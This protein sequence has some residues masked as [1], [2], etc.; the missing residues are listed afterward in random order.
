MN[1]QLGISALLQKHTGVGGS[2]W[3]VGLNQVLILNEG[4]GGEAIRVDIGIDRRRA[5]TDPDVVDTAS[6]HPEA[7]DMP[8]F[9]PDTARLLTVEQQCERLEESLQMLR[10]LVHGEGGNGSQLVYSEDLAILVGEVD[11]MCDLVCLTVGYWSLT[12]SP[13]RGNRIEQKTQALASAGEEPKRWWF[14]AMTQIHANAMHRRVPTVP[15]AHWMYGPD[16]NLGGGTWRDNLGKKRE[17]GGTQRVIGL[18]DIVPGAFWADL[19]TYS[20]GECNSE[21]TAVRQALYQAMLGVQKS[22]LS[23][24]TEL[25]CVQ[26]GDVQTW[27][28]SGEAC[29]QQYGLPVTSETS[30]GSQIVLAGDPKLAAT[31]DRQFQVKDVHIAVERHIAAV[32][33]L[34]ALI[35]KEGDVGRALE[36]LAVATDT[37]TPNLRRAQGPYLPFQRCYG[38]NVH[39]E[40]YPAIASWGDNAWSN[41]GFS[42]SGVWGRREVEEGSLS[43]QHPDDG[44]SEYKRYGRLQS[45]QMQ[46]TTRFL[47]LPH[48]LRNFP[49][50]CGLLET[51]PLPSMFGNGVRLY[52]TEEC[53]RRD[54]LSVSSVVERE[55][56][57]ALEEYALVSKTAWIDHFEP[58]SLASDLTPIEPMSQLARQEL[59][60][61]KSLLAGTSDTGDRETVEFA[62]LSRIGTDTTPYIAATTE[63][64]LFCK[65]MRDIVASQVKQMQSVARTGAKQ[66]SEDALAD[67]DC[68]SYFGVLRHLNSLAEVQ[69][70]PE[71]S[72]QLTSAIDWCRG[73]VKTALDKRS[74]TR[75]KLKPKPLSAS[76]KRNATA[77]SSA[78]VV[79]SPS[80]SM[81]SKFHQAFKLACETLDL[82]AARNHDPQSQIIR[83]CKEWILA[84][85]THARLSRSASVMTVHCQ[86]GMVYEP[87]IRHFLCTS[88]GRL[89]R[90]LVGIDMGGGC[91]LRD[92]PLTEMFAGCTYFASGSTRRGDPWPRLSALQFG[93]EAIMGEIRRS[94]MLLRQGGA[95]ETAN[96]ELKPGVLRQSDAEV[97]RERWRR[98][99]AH[100]F[101]PSQ[102]FGD[103]LCVLNLHYMYDNCAASRNSLLKIIS[104]LDDAEL[105]LCKQW[106]TY[107]HGPHPFAPISQSECEY[108]NGWGDLNQAVPERE[109]AKATACTVRGEHIQTRQ[110][111]RSPRPI[112]ST[113][114][115]TRLLESERLCRIYH[116]LLSVFRAGQLSPNRLVKDITYLVSVHTPLPQQWMTVFIDLK[117]DA[118][119]FLSDRKSREQ[120]SEEALS[121]FRDHDAWIS[122]S[123]GADAPRILDQTGRVQWDLLRAL[124]DQPRQNHQARYGKLLQLASSL[125]F[126]KLLRTPFRAFDRNTFPNYGVVQKFQTADET[127]TDH[128]CNS[129]SADATRVEYWP[130]PKVDEP[131]ATSP[132]GMSRADVY[133]LVHRDNVDGRG[134][135]PSEGWGRRF[136]LDS[137]DFG[138]LEG[139]EV[140]VYSTSQGCIGETADLPEPEDNPQF[141]ILVQEL[142]QKVKYRPEELVRTGQRWIRNGLNCV[143]GHDDDG[144]HPMEE[145]S[146]G[147]GRER[148]VTQSASIPPNPDLLE[149]LSLEEQQELIRERRLQSGAEGM[150]ERS[151]SAH[152]PPA[153][154]N[155]L[156]QDLR[157][158]VRTDTA[159]KKALKWIPNDTD[160][161]VSTKTTGSWEFLPAGYEQVDQRGTVRERTSESP[162]TS[163]G[164][165]P[166]PRGVVLH[167]KHLHV[168]GDKNESDS[169]S[170]SSVSDS[171]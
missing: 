156:P 119:L 68:K 6:L 167:P 35:G 104:L 23:L 31:V 13:G 105:N 53:L 4:A 120:L 99:S 3:A 16:N 110:T 22:G 38:N 112:V 73:E 58:L 116:S 158:V 129:L 43:M 98:S 95:L 157:D 144:D 168:R 137:L 140:L 33:G 111:G 169:I 59:Q 15:A 7:E 124:L 69:R 159:V 165:H 152:L 1:L 85:Q 143:G 27:T 122:T 5:R 117:E 141:Q 65:G 42:T 28:S 114:L 108:P 171:D 21:K 19:D 20:R 34:L 51:H 107:S 54:L 121:A 139:E 145:I 138:S 72:A 97:K 132:R 91:L 146:H 151:P 2:H 66:F 77:P 92:E 136:G 170:D 149:P 49:F 103:E 79:Y 123:A 166:V 10:L 74:K 100:A 153:K 76:A 161:R 24:R 150:R 39:L 93:A 57:L 8:G 78:L 11:R 163:V 148:G 36:A 102:F 142:L 113:L 147:W 106:V 75:S 128:R 109:L 50:V 30:V 86:P 127:A 71:L 101:V 62:E 135:V 18:E 155:L 84:F 47:A 26:L 94:E 82:H 63:E 46:L 60:L 41:F 32:G 25:E 64:E 96:G 162:Q 88:A 45:I 61:R 70:P 52:K 118:E 37:F 55:R 67:A 48:V 87:S 40:E 160:G 164:W 14:F 17:S 12:L 81:E 125:G 130:F 126:G 131:F 29:C 115:S 133:E 134:S 80:I 9:R 154:F 90:F 44:L 56:Q 83:T 89:T